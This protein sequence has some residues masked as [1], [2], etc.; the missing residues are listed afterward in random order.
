[1][2]CFNHGRFL[3]KSVN[4]VLGQ[5]H[6]NLELIIIDD[7]SSDNSWEEIKRFAAEDSRIIALRHERNQ[8][9]SKSR[10]DGLQVA[11]GEF[12]AFCD[13]DDIWERKKL[14]SQL[15]LLRSNLAY[16]VAYCDALIIDENGLPT[17]KRF[18]ELLF[19]PRIPSGWLFRKLIGHNFIN[20]QSVLMRKECVQSTGHFDEDLKVLED[21]W[22]WIR[23][24]HH[25]RFLYSR[26]LLGRYRMHA[27]STYVGQK[28][29]Y[30]FSRYKVFKRVLREYADISRCAKA[31]IL[32]KMGVDLYGLGKKRASRLLLRNAIEIAVR[33]IRA[34]NILG[35]ALA[36]IV[37]KFRTS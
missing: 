9:V 12:I 27:N 28:R 23:L 8:G 19:L 36:R 29:R 1:M 10:N 11:T 17:G 4:G 26:E 21:W 18:S 35:K 3:R 34:F 13:A 32:Y 22:Y 24:S 15:D 31:N 14:K 7:G 30:C 6:E 2:P 20:T 33:D 5:S 25:H 37:I 16:D